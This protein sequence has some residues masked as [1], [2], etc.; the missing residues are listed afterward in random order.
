[1]SKRI[2]IVKELRALE[3]HYSFKAVRDPA[4]HERFLK[5][6]LA[7][8][9]DFPLESI[10]AACAEWRRSEA[11]RMPTSGQLIPLIRKHLPVE[12]RDGQNQ[13]WRELSDAEYAALSVR[14]KIR[15]QEILAMEAGKRAGP[16]R[17][18]VPEPV[19]PEAWMLWKPRQQQHAEEAR[20]LRAYLRPM[21]NAA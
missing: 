14:G 12:K 3:Q 7:D 6:F 2:E 13:P 20:R 17:L 19:N 15:H 4:D 10:K 18:D 21:E 8:I 9:E 11:K 5:D 16:M 1:M